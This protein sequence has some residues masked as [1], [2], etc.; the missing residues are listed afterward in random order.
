VVLA[1]A[2]AALDGSCSAAAYKQYRAKGNAEAKLIAKVLPRYMWYRFLGDI[3]PGSWVAFI[4]GCAADSSVCVGTG[5]EPAIII[6]SCQ[7]CACHVVLA[8]AVLCC[9]VLLPLR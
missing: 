8:S 5:C 9:A 7:G 6:V 1:L 4:N 2:L 3:H